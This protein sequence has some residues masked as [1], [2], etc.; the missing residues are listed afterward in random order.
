MQFLNYCLWNDL[1]IKNFHTHI[2][3]IFWQEISISLITSLFTSIEKL[4]SLKKNIVKL[5][6]HY[7][8]TI[9]INWSSINVLIFKVWILKRHC[10]K[11]LPEKL[12]QGSTYYCTYCNCTK[13]LQKYW[14][15]WKMFIMCTVVVS[16]WR[17]KCFNIPK[18]FNFG[19]WK[20]H[21]YTVNAM[22][23]SILNLIFA[24]NDKKTFA[25]HI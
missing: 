6:K 21:L 17:S 11:K 1:F 23:L 5:L 19:R 24:K 18:I 3:I 13:Y 14:S 16:I 25:V 4:F 10:S 22:P 12:S 2:T 15:F 8:I 20:Y 9:N 7:T